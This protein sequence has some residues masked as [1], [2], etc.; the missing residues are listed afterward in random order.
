MKRNLTSAAICAKEIRQFLKEN[1][2]KAKFNVRSENFAGGDSVHIDFTDSPY[3]Y[4][5][6]R[7]AVKKFQ[8]GHFNGM[9]DSYEYDNAIEGITQVKFIL[10]KRDFSDE[11]KQR[12]TKEL[13][14]RF[15]T[16]YKYN[17]YNDYLGNYMSVY[18]RRECS[19]QRFEN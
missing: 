9:T 15:H 17:D 8:Y 13:N 6:V 7:E 19:K 12:I 1:F 4:E 5:E 11:V 14:E 16:N 2:P 18:V 10:V 3:L